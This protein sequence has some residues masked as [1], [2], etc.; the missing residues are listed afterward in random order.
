MSVLF[1]PS[2]E[3]KTCSVLLNKINYLA[4]LLFLPSYN[5]TTRPAHLHELKDP[6]TLVAFIQQMSRSVLMNRSW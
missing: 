5:Q 2:S 3:N 6:K 1:S 4:L